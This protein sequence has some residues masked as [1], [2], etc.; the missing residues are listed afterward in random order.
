MSMGL[1]FVAA[2]RPA[3]VRDALPTAGELNRLPLARGGTYELTPAQ[4][5]VARSR[6]YSLNREN[7]AGWRWRTMT[8]TGSRG[9]VILTIWRVK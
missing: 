2:A 5:L 9:K 3:I 6:V 1:D 7:A 4:V 8:A